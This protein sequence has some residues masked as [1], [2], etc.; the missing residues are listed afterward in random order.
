MAYR[1]RT[2]KQFEK[3]VKRCIKRG[4]S[5]DKLRRAMELLEQNG[6]LPDNYRP[7][8]LHGKR[9]GQWEC[10]I[11]PDWLLIWEQYEE[12][13]LMLMINTGSRSDLFGKK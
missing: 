8:L 11:E 10:H 9:D 6:S 2:T 12:E 4:L 13:L 3:D 1:L 7:H 5:M